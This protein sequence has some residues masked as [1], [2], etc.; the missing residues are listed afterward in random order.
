MVSPDTLILVGN[1]AGGAGSLFTVL[2]CLAL[3]LYLINARA[4]SLLIRKNFIPGAEGKLIQPSLGAVTATVLP[5]TGRL[6]VAVFGASGMLVASGFVF[7]EVFFHK[8][9]NFAFAFLLLAVLLA[10]HLAGRKAAEVSQFIF[11]SIAVIGL[12]FLALVGLMGHSDTE[13]NLFIFHP[14]I[15]M[16]AV[17]LPLWFFVGFDLFIYIRRGQVP[18]S[19]MFY[20]TVIGLLTAAIVL[21]LWANVSLAYVPAEK[22]AETTIP[23]I[24]AARKVFGL[25]GR[26]IMG[27]IVIAGSCAAVNM[28]F[29]GIACLLRAMADDRRLPFAWGRSKH[30]VKFSVIGLA[31]LVAV[32]MAMGMAGSE[33]LDVIIHT[34]LILWL[35]YYSSV[36]FMLCLSAWRQKRSDQHTVVHRP[37]WHLVG[38]ITMILGIIALVI[39]YPETDILLRVL[40]IVLAIMISLG[41]M[42]TGLERLI[43]KK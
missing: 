18:A 27:V 14:P 28:L 5:L 32:M 36:H 25:S 21:G 19:G 31:A 33:Y 12:I 34:G 17:F 23:H 42:L 40:F 26:F 38:F 22:L 30:S 11:S 41:V 37:S 9:P 1:S 7:N 24:L 2:M 8:F 29:S 3:L 6:L 35:T 43:A 10:I 39:T 20:Q 13:S 15:H 16:S 4:F